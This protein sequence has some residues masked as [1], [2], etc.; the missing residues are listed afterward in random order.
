MVILPAKIEISRIIMLAKQCHKRP[1][2]GNG[3]HTTYKGN[4]LGDGLWHCF[5]HIALSTSPVRPMMCN[6]V[7]CVNLAI[8]RPHLLVVEFLSHL[9]FYLLIH[10]TYLRQYVAFAGWGVHGTILLLSMPRMYVHHGHANDKEIP[11]AF[12]QE[13]VQ[14]NTSSWAI[15][16]P[17]IY[18]YGSFLT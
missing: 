13:L 12:G 9:N 4:D 16:S 10:V 15:A 11:W 14:Q 7:M 8:K 2:I 1:M 3:N 6:Q 18:R 5:T 17:Q